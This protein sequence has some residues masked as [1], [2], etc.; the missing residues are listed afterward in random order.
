MLGNIFCN[1]LIE[2]WVHSKLYLMGSSIADNN[3]A[4]ETNKEK[5]GQTHE[6]VAAAVHHNQ[7]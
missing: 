5:E 3:T 4:V 7:T 6:Q 1:F 2:K